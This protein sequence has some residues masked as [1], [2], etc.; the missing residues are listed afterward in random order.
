MTNPVSSVNRSS[1]AD[2]VQQAQR[3]NQNE[4]KQQAPAPRRANS[5]ANQDKVTLSKNHAAKQNRNQR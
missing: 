4:R 5:T 3:V 2:Q 1:Q